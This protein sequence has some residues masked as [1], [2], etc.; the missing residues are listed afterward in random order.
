MRRPRVLVSAIMVLLG[1]VWIGQG[2]GAITGSAMSGNAFWAVI[3]VILVVGGLVIAVREMIRRP[4][5][6]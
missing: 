3:G 2:S 4:A 1:F 6:P 5:R